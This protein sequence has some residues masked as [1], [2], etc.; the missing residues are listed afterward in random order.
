MGIIERLIDKFIAWRYRRDLGERY[1]RPRSE[2]N[3]TEVKLDRKAEAMIA[4][5]KRITDATQKMIDNYL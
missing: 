2:E 3:P 5:N 1:E 4:A